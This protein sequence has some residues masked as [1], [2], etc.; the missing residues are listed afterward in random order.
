MA[1]ATLAFAPLRVFMRLLSAT[2][3]LAD[4]A[5]FFAEVVFR[6]IS[7]SKQTVLTL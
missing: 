6:G 7:K 3:F 5:N 2:F 1:A 4:F